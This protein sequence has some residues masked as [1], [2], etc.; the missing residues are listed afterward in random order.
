[1]PRPPTAAR[2]RRAAARDDNPN[3]YSAIAIIVLPCHLTACIPNA[4]YILRVYVVMY[5]V[6]AC[7]A[8]TCMLY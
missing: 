2:A 3:D 1:M 8:T 4:Y 6:Y 5:V 7:C